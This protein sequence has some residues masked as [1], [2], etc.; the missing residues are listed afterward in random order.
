ML[1]ERAHRTATTYGVW[2]VVASFAGATGGGFDTTAGRSTIVT[3]AGE[4]VARAGADPGELV[5]ATLG[6]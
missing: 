6:S 2:V 3:P 4:V 5:S 1:A